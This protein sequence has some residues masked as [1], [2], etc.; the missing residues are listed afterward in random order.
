LLIGSASL[1]RLGG[2]L[3]DEAL[4]RLFVDGRPPKTCGVAMRTGVAHPVDG[5]YRVSGR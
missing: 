4:E 2:F 1:G 5:G 3:P